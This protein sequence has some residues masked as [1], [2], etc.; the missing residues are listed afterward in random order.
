MAD[1]HCVGAILYNG[2]GEILLQL[3]DD[4]PEIIF[5]NHWTTLGGRIEPGES[6]AEAMRRELMEEIEIAPTLTLW[7]VVE[8]P[9]MFHENQIVVEQ[10]FFVGELDCDADTI[11]LH[12]GQVVRFFGP[13]DLTDLPIAFG[14][15][16]YFR[17]FF[18]TAKQ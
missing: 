15:E 14:F 3:R 17:A 18:E 12:E 8:N 11:H 5:P 7:Q 9:I 1:L 10:Y 16:A 2:Q 13:D 6:P 4:K